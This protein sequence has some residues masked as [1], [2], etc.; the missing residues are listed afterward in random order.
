MIIMYFNERFPLIK[1]N[2]NSN[3]ASNM[4]LSEILYKAKVRQSFKYAFTKVT[5]EFDYFPLQLT[6]AKR[7]GK[8]FFNKF[9]L[10]NYLNKPKT[11]N[12]SCDRI[13]YIRE[14]KF[15]LIVKNKSNLRST[16]ARMEGS[17]NIN[18]TL[19]TE[20]L[21]RNIQFYSK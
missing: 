8:S 7:F 13:G 11:F 12:K 5:S 18:A 6:E 2:E 21:N 17:R 16:S 9:R 1:T 19:R 4:N 10:N 14:R 20:N 3:I 15:E